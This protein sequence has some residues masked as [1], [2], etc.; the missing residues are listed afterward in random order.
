LLLTACAIVLIAAIIKKKPDYLI[1]AVAHLCLT[2]PVFFMTGYTWGNL[3][4][5][6]ISIVSLF[7]VFNFEKLKKPMIILL[8]LLLILFGYMLYISA[9]GNMMAG[10]L[11]HQL[12]SFA[13]DVNESGGKVMVF[14]TEPVLPWEINSIGY[15]YFFAPTLTYEQ[16]PEMYEQIY[17]DVSNGNLDYILVL[18]DDN[19][20]IMPLSHFR[21]ANEGELLTLQWV[22]KIANE[23]Y[24]NYEIHGKYYRFTAF[25]VKGA[26]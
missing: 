16:F 8:V 23:I 24:E 6:F 18:L 14:Q 17:A 10:Q 13:E 1:L 3:F 9:S 2:I 7:S 5:P 26:K 21:T 19:G 4:T 25:K 20:N 11:Y 15:K 22:D 12:D